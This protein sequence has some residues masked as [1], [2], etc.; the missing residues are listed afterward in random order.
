MEGLRCPGVGTLL[1]HVP[2]YQAAGVL[3]LVCGARDTHLYPSSG[4]VALK[5]PGCGV[6]AR[7]AVEDHSATR[8]DREHSRAG[9]APYGCQRAEH[10][11]VHAHGKAVRGDPVG[12]A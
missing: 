3:G 2:G 9:S 5:S 4:E 12:R 11:E 10:S 6:R 1:A 7:A 8:C